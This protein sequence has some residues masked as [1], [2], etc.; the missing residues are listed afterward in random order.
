MLIIGFGCNTAEDGHQHDGR[1]N[2]DI[3]END[4]A[5]VEAD[6]K[7][8]PEDSRQEHGGEL[9]NGELMF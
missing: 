9:D 3:V 4:G 5:E 8:E 1:R 6:D 7:Y 2:V